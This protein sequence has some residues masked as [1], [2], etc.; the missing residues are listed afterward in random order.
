MELEDKVRRRTA[1][2]EA[3]NQELEPF[4]YAISHDLKA[5]LKN[6]H[7][8]SLPNAY[9]DDLL[10]RQV[11]QN[12][13]SQARKHAAHQESIQIEVRGWTEED[14]L[15][16]N[17]RDNRVGF[18]PDAKHKLFRILQQVRLVSWKYCPLWP[19]RAILSRFCSAEA[20]SSKR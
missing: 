5:P 4:T 18:S 12:V 3:V 9:G 14:M 13:L 17:V 7:G 20:E 10:I 19:N 11:V 2:L 15:V 16:C 1:Q 6:L 8:F